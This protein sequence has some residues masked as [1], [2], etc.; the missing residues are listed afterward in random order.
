MGGV[1]LSQIEGNDTYKLPPEITFFLDTSNPSRPITDVTINAVSITNPYGGS[2]V[3]GTSPVQIKT[4]LNSLYT[5]PY[6]NRTAANTK[7]IRIGISS[8]NNQT[9]AM[10]KN[11]FDYTTRVAGFPSASVETGDTG[12]E[13]YIVVHGSDISDTGDYDIKAVATNATYTALLYGVG[14]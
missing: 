14:G 11:Y 1:F 10:W 13:S 4:T 3:G 2:V 7:W 9:R 12:T 8:Q 5:F 6:V